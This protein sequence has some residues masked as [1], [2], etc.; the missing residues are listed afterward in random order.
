MEQFIKEYL[1]KVDITTNILSDRVSFLYKVAS[2][3]CPEKIERIFIGDY[4]NEDK[5]RG[6]ESIWFFSKNFILEAHDFETKYELDIVPITVY[7]LMIEL[8]D[9]D[10]CKATEESRMRVSLTFAED[11]TGE[12]KA[13]KENCDILRDIIFTYIQP[14]FGN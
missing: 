11:L 10:F 4:I 12:L 3:M 7:R 6:Y 5:S 1:H 13:A 2:K 8:K 9:Y 14:R